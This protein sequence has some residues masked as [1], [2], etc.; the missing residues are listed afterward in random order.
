MRDETQKY[1]ERENV[2]KKEKRKEMCVVLIC[3]ESENK[4]RKYRR[5]L[6]TRQKNYE[7]RG[8]FRGEIHKDSKVI[9][10]PQSGKIYI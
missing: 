2:F 1:E 5:K 6:N 3:F 9:C 4:R 8:H 10:L 7:E